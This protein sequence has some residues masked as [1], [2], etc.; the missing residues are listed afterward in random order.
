[1][2]YINKDKSFYYK[3]KIWGG[4]WLFWL[5]LTTPLIRKVKFFKRLSKKFTYFYKLL[6]AL[7]LKTKQI[8]FNF[9]FAGNSHNFLQN[10]KLKKQ[11]TKGMPST[12][13]K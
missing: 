2:K 12:Q 11:A 4:T 8:H 6:I 7:F 13:T 5:Y 10:A 1:M 3:A 9:L